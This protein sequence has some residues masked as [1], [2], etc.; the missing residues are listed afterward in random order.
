MGFRVVGALF[1]LRSQ[2]AALLFQLQGYYDIELAVGLIV[3]ESCRRSV[4]ELDLAVRLDEPNLVVAS[5]RVGLL[6]NLAGF[7]V[8]SWDF[9]GVGFWRLRALGRDHEFEFFRGCCHDQPNLKRQPE[10]LKPQP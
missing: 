1:S 5:L 8:A 4:Y 9:V 2:M 6:F 3:L 7:D 10:A